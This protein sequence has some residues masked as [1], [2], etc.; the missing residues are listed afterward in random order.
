MPLQSP[1]LQSAP[2]IIHSHRALGLY[3]PQRKKFPDPNP[4]YV[5]FDGS[6]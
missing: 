1:E 5:T 2:I 6:G 4:V 3:L